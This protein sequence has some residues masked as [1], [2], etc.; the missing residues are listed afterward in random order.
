MTINPQLTLMLGK[1]YTPFGGKKDRYTATPGLTQQLTQSNDVLAGAKWTMNSGV[2]GQAWAYQHAVGQ[3]ANRL[4][5]W[6]ALIGI[7]T[8]VSAITGQVKLAWINDLRT[9]LAD[10]IIPAVNKRE[11]AWHAQAQAAYGPASLHVDYTRAQ[12]AIASNVNPRVWHV[13]AAY[14]MSALGH[15]HHIAAGYEHA[16]KE[17]ATLVA[18]KHQYV[19]YHVNLINH[20]EGSVAYDHFDAFAG[21][22]IN[23][24]TTGIRV[25]F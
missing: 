1:T 25:Q 13:G 3:E 4:N 23:R 24:V 10:S 12:D 17:S 21:Q 11:G 7:N 22:D 18:H 15:D 9:V 6:G 14:H 16:S 20:V 5:K 8:K 19:R 2:F